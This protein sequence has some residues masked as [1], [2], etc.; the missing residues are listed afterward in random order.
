MLL[1][2]VNISMIETIRQ[3]L[4]ETPK[5][6]RKAALTPEMR[7]F[8]D[9]NY[10]TNDFPYQCE[11]ALSN[12][13]IPSC[14]VCGK[15]PA[16]RKI[17]CSRECREQL[18]K[19]NGIDSFAAAKKSMKE[20]YGVDNAAHI[21]G[22]QQ[23]R[24]VTMVE[25]YGS[26]VSDVTRKKAKQRA[27]DLNKKG[28]KTLKEKYGVDNPAQL[29]T[30][31]HKVRQTLLKNYG[32]DN[33][34][35]SVEWQ[36]QQETR[37]LDT[38]EKLVDDMVSILDISDPD[39]DIL[40]SY[41][42]PNKRVSFKCKSCGNEEIIPTETLK[43]RIRQMQTPCS[44]C[45]NISGKGSHAEKEITNWIKV[46][47][48]LN[49]IEND[50]VL[51]SPMEVD[52]VIPEKKVAVEYCG[53]YWHN[54]QRI[55]K[56]YHEKK[57]KLCEEAGYKLITIFEDEWIHKSEI[58]KERLRSKLGMATIKVGARKCD[59]VEI[60]S[61]TAAAFMNET[62]IQGYLNSS[63]RYGLEYNGK[64]LAVMTFVKGNIS[65]KVNGWELSRFSIKGGYSMPGAANRLFNRFLRDHSPNDVVTFSDLRWNTGEVYE[66]MG[67]E[68]VGHTGLNY[69]YIQRDKR[70]HRYNL[71]KTSE[72]PSNIS[73]TDLR[74]T[75]GWLRIWD[76]GNN[77][78]V[79]SKNS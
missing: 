64:L 32:V 45:S 20:Q 15:L 31:Q 79:W 36:R 19:N 16:R 41:D 3:I 22:N 17:T 42:K 50:R 43:Y 60:D 68:F 8:L 6:S 12:E 52:I 30:H 9:T 46:E 1:F 27:N 38:L 71:R 69:W 70:I 54:D 7:E 75:Q 72:D 26:K 11:L 49:I 39:F 48:G 21:P 40:T 65:K 23:K 56:D 51:I 10:P 4:S 73:E 59:I 28:R 2:V 5:K 44:K 67:F 25:K 18:K 24:L 61:K 78:Y 33:F 34:F 55:S 74:R 66:Q 14:P 76:C 13:P 53:L 58:V 29:S 62:H 63:V 77:K 37:R 47:F 35:E 57:R